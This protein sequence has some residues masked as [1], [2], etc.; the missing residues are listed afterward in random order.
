MLAAI[1]NQTL[2][3]T[4]GGVYRLQQCD[5]LT[6][7]VCAKSSGNWK[8]RE[9]WSL[10]GGVDLLLVALLQ[11]SFPQQLVFGLVAAC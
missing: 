5:L 1:S 7:P 6:E 2:C 3:T 10:A 11:A 4:V 8:P 9:M